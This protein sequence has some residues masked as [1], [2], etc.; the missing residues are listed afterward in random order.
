MHFCIF[1]CR[2]TPFLKT[3]EQFENMVFIIMSTRENIRLI[4]RAPIQIAIV[5][6]KLVWFYSKLCIVSV[7]ILFKVIHHLQRRA[8]L[9]FRR[10]PLILC[11]YNV[12]RLNQTLSKLHCLFSKS[13][14]AKMFRIKM[15]VISWTL[16]YT[17]CAFVR[18]I[19]KMRSSVIGMMKL[20]YINFAFRCFPPPPTPKMSFEQYVLINS[21]GT[22]MLIQ[23]WFNV[24]NICSNNV[25]NIFEFETWINADIQTLIQSWHTNVDS[26]LTY[27]RWFNVDIQ[28]LNQHWY[29]NTDS[30]LNQNWIDFDSTSPLN[31]IQH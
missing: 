20:V 23:C 27:K 12:C 25:E 9:P 10:P 26:T 8:N 28:A 29:F 15:L 22:S 13:K 4:A 31:Q 14:R 21:A 7:K 3:L 17:F 19:L 16:W 1:Y 30:T 6:L 2:T 5:F 24:D 18:N 11:L